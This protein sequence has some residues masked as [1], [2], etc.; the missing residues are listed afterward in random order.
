MRGTTK[1]AIG[2]AMA[3][4][5]VL[6]VAAPAAAQEFARMRH[7]K[8]VK[9]MEVTLGLLHAWNAQDRISIILHL[10]KPHTYCIWDGGRS[11]E[12]Q[13]K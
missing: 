10:Q 4:G 11:L 6:A 8:G 13:R 2:A 7:W 1:L 9:R 3:C 5:A 12:L